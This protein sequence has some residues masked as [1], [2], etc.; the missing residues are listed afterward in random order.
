MSIHTESVTKAFGSF[1]ALTDVSV[2]IP[3]GRLT[4]HGLR[5]RAARRSA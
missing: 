3:S 4:A 2:D 1:A 5:L